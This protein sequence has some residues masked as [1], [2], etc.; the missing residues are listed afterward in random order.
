MFLYNP[1]LAGLQCKTKVTGKLK[2]NMHN[3][4]LNDPLYISIRKGLTNLNFIEYF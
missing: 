4:R 1:Q 2:Q 3:I